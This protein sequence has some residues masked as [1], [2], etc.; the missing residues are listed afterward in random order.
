MAALISIGGDF[1]GRVIFDLDPQT[2]TRVASF[3]AGTT[4]PESDELVHDTICELANQVIGN[5][6]TSLNNQGFRFK[7]QP[8][9]F[10]TSDE[11]LQCSEDTEALVI[12]FDTPAGAVYMN[13][14]MRYCRTQGDRAS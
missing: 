6:I 7:A 11:G 4:L 14:G 1:E 5:A 3:L 10:H 9:K 12:C 13:I 2:A 8:P